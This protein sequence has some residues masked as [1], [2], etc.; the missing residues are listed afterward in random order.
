MDIRKTGTEYVVNFVGKKTATLCV[1]FDQRNICG[2]VKYSQI[3]VFSTFFES[4]LVRKVA[5]T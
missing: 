5:W 2:I 1:D 3:D 4:K